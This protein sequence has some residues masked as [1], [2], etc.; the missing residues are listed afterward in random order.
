MLSKKDVL[1]YAKEQ[2]AKDY[3]CQIKDLEQ[4]SNTLSENLLLDGRRVYE[5]E[6][7]FLKILCFGSC[8]V[9]SASETIHPYLKDNYLSRNSSWLFDFEN[10]RAIDKHLS[11]FG[12]E[13]GELSVYY[14]PN[15]DR[16]AFI[17]PFKVKWFE[18]DDIEQ[19]RADKRFQEAYIFD[20]DCPDVLGI[21]AY[22]EE[23][24]I[25]G[26][27]GATSD[28][29]NL[30]QI[31]IDVIDAYRHRGI[32]ASLVRLLKNELLSRGLVPFIK[33]QYPI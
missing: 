13:I 26:M 9:F 27:A 28:T 22:D 24:Q 17:A 30:Y 19:F 3:N 12:H 11:G 23:G 33:P 20:L 21:G 8:A 15:P 2:L 18:K 6:G 4:R 25:M 32:G 14:L 29:D 16:E 10:L 7:A 1:N 31:G 5:G